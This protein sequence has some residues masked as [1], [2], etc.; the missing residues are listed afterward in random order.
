MVSLKTT[1]LVAVTALAT[2]AKADY[3]IDPTTVP[4][5]TR[6]ELQDT[7]GRPELTIC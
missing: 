7:S 5:S 2:L 4:Q 3:V 1:G 6:G